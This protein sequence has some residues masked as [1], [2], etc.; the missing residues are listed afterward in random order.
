MVKKEIYQLKVTLKHSKPAIWRRILVSSDMKLSDFHYVLQTTMG[1]TNFHLH[2][3]IKDGSYYSDRMADDDFW[4]DSIN[5]DYKKL[6][7]SSLLQHEKDKMIY[8][9]DFGD[10]WEHEILLEKVLPFDK[11]RVLPVCVAG[12]MH[13]PPEDC[14]GVWGFEEMIEILKQPKHPEYN[15]YMEWLEDDF[16]PASFSIDEVNEGLGL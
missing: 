8:E 2:Q 11:A 15:N 14:G 10:G 7:V 16:D 12:K 5:V 4:H 3:F 13:C 6:K 1:W 9:Y